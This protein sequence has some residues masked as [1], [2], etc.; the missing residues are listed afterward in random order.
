MTM[1]YELQAT[2]VNEESP[3]ESSLDLTLTQHIHDEIP[4]LWEVHFR[5]KVEPFWTWYYHIYLNFWMLVILL[6]VDSDSSDEPK[7][8]YEGFYEIE[9]TSIFAQSS[10]PMLDTIVG[11]KVWFIDCLLIAQ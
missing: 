1:S 5:F 6:Q 8:V 9:K 10:I 3:R 4:K 7:F 11:C 2:Q